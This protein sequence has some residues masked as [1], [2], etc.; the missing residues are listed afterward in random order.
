MKQLFAGLLLCLLAPSLPAQS[1]YFPPN[2]NTV[3]ETISPQSLG[4]CP[5]EIDSLYQLLDQANSKAFLL[6]KDGKIVLEKYFDGFT[7]DSLWYWASAGKTMTAMLTGIA[8]QEGHLSLSDTTSE[9]LGKK[10][11]SCTP[12][13]EEKITVWHQLTMSSGLDDGVTDPYCTLSS[14]LQYKAD[15]GTR[16]AYHNAPYTL[17]DGVLE[18][19]TGQT[20]NAYYA[21]KIRN[22]TGMNGLFLPSGYN[23]VLFSTPRSMARFGLLV[24]NKGNWNGTPI[25]KDSAYFKQMVNTSQAL[26]PSYGYLWWLNGKAS[27]RVPGL[28]VSFPGPLFP[29]APADMFAALGKNGQFISIVPSQNLLFVRMGDSPGVGEVPYLLCNDIWAKINRLTCAATGTA[30]ISAGDIAIYPNPATSSFR[31]D[32]P[33]DVADWTL[34]VRDITGRQLGVYQNPTAISTEAWANGLYFLT[35]RAGGQEWVRKLVVA[36]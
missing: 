11:T 34:A 36:R 8:Q 17:L 4:Y 29:D 27:Y 31:I 1:L 24:L 26:N 13:Q 21:S 19:A 16:W 22:P 33:N 18:S 5:A 20:L 7:K 25:L 9:Y 30:A 28:Q 6:L 12:A 14:C 23:N 32:M 3:W 35:I 2:N 10:W 15:A